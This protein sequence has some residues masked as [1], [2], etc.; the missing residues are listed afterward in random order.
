M[1]RAYREAISLLDL[2][3]NGNE[4]IQDSEEKET[5]TAFQDLCSTIVDRGSNSTI[6]YYISKILK[7]KDSESLSNVHKQHLESFG[8]K[9]VKGN[10]F[11]AIKNKNLLASCKDY[12]R[13]SKL[14]QQDT[15]LFL[16][17]GTAKISGV[18][19]KGI[20]VSLE[21]FCLESNSDKE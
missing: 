16:R 17:K 7:N 11:I 5:D 6:G 21:N 1:N 4:Y 20:F 19:T 8:L 14:L 2:K 13:L 18:D 10:L 15:E 3:N 12:P 9:I